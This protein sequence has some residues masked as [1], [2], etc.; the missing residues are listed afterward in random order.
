MRG[1]CERS[2]EDEEQKEEAMVACG[3]LSGVPE[4]EQ[5]PE[6]NWDSDLETEGTDGLGE[7]VRDTLYLRSCRAH[8]VVPISCFL[9]QG[10]AQELNLRHRGLGPQGARA[11]ASSLSSNPYVKRL[12]LRDNGLCGAGAEALAGALSKSSSIHDVD[13]SENQLGVAG[14]QALCAALTVNQAMRKMQLSGNGL[15]EQAAQH[16]AELLLAHTDLK[17]LD[18]SYNQ[19]NDQAVTTASLRWEP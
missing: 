16:L 7:L 8:S 19:L 11:L 18:L 3:R 15:E 9:R 17:S 13:L 10:S 12:D 14:A 2:G 1:S 6:A 4:A 5:G